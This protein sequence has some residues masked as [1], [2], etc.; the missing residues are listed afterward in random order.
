MVSVHLSRQPYPWLGMQGV[1]REDGFRRLCAELPALNLFEQ[2]F[3]QARGYGQQSQDRYVRRAP[4][5][6]CSSW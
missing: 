4:C 3:G 2:E 1:I 6:R 5:A